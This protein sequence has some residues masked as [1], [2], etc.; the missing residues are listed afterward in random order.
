MLRHLQI[1]NYAI[2][3]GISL[4]F[5]R[6]LQV[7]TG[8]TGAGKSI[9]AGALSLVLGERADSSVLMQREKKC[10]VE[11]TFEAEGKKEVEDFLAEQGLD[12]GKELLLRREISP[13]GKSRAFVNDT[14]VNLEQLRKLSIQLV[15]LHQQFDIIL[16][17]ESDF[18]LSVIDALAGH[19]ALLREYRLRFQEWRGLQ[20]A[21]DALKARQTQA[22]KENDYQK[23][24]FSELQEAGFA[25]EEVEK[26]EAELK[27]LSHAEAIKA[28]LSGIQY[29]MQSSDNPL[30]Q[31]I[32]AIGQQLSPYSDYHAKFPGLIQRLQSVHIEMQDIAGELESL[33]DEVQHDPEQIEKL[34]ERIHTGYKLFKKHHVNTTTALIQLQTELE[35]KLQ[36]TL[37][38]AEEIHAKE[39]QAEAQIKEL[40]ALAGKLSENRKKQLRGFEEQ[41]NG[42]LKKVGMSSAR[43]RIQFTETTLR[44]SGK[45]EIEFLFDANNSGRFEPL[46]KVASGGELSRLMLCIKSLVARSLDMP[47][48]LFDEIDSGI[49]GEAARQV[50]IILKELSRNRQVICIT[51][52]P[53]IAGKGDAHYYVYKEERKGKVRTGVRLLDNEERIHVIAK[54]L[55]GEKPTAAALENAR[56][57]VK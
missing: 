11:A 7:I 10:I 2:L 44:D 17:G 26:A 33:S 9:M 3:E 54:M 6:G 52:Q 23:F 46:K 30:L 51:H 1:Q 37:N 53:Q 41:V 29:E 42:L 57:L 43:I 32:R 21:L 35:Q 16:L 24:L 34:N 5:T 20:L 25:E 38:L 13:N 49:S 56:E 18:Q 39:K 50:G 28:L 40:T 12:S 45:D 47:T 19:A 4:D 31:K 55:S 15:D 8:E 27:L 22:D 48:L 36:E 14:P